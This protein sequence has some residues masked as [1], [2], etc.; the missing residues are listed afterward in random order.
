MIN[1]GAQLASK[2]VG[3]SSAIGAIVSSVEMYQS[4]LAPEGRPAGIFLLL[5][6][7]G[8]GKTRTVEVLAEVLHGNPKNMLKINCGEYQAEHEVAKL[9]GAPPGYLGHRETSPIL[10]Q[11]AL[12]NVA[13]PGCDLSL[14]LFD[15]IEKAAPSLA[16]LLLGVFDKG[17]LGLGDGS[18]VYFEHTMIFMTSNLGAREMARETAPS[19]GFQ[20]AVPVGDVADKLERV[21]M[22]AVKRKFSPEFINRID[23][24]I[25]YQPLAAAN[26]SSITDHEVNSLQLHIARRLGT[27]SFI[28]DVPQSV[29][30]WLTNEGTS[31]EY[32]AREL[33]RTMHRHLSQPLAS[34]VARGEVAPG[35]FV[36]VSVSRDGR[37]LRISPQKMVAMAGGV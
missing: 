34:L 8:T 2:V 6:P 5:G 19:L 27:R 26:F 22:T 23:R 3:Q 30:R 17:T 11:K 4:G 15:E 35:S 18:T 25:T 16:R 33:K 1:I 12:G 28:L 13:S 29:R 36:R 7:T 9:I 37:S 10:M 20:S 32:G 31:V 14:I 21:A 24:V